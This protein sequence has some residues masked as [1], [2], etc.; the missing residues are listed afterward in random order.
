MDT[1]LD[2]G[3]TPCQPHGTELKGLAIGEGFGGFRL[4]VS[5]LD[6][7]NNRCYHA[8]RFG[9]NASYPCASIELSDGGLRR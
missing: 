2:F 6:R 1:E 9:L 4:R 5:L 3:D 8:N 7:F